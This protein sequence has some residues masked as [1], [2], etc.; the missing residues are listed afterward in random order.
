MIKKKISKEPVEEKKSIIKI[1]PKALNIFQLKQLKDNGFDIMKVED[2]NS[3]DNE[4]AWSM[5]MAVAEIFFTKEELEELPGLPV[6]EFASK[7]VMKTHNMD[8]E[9]K[10]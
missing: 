8:D 7:C 1:K 9:S 5:F 10:N 2:F 3:D 6:I 4:I